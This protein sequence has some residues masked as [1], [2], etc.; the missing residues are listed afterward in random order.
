MK[1]VGKSVL[2]IILGLMMIAKTLPAQTSIPNGSFEDWINNGNSSDPQYWDT[3]NYELMQIPF[4][5]TTVVTKSTDHYGTGS[6]SVKLESKHIT[7]PSIDVPG[8]IT[9][10]KLNIDMISGTYSVT[11][12]VPIIDKPTHLKGYYKFIPKGGDSTLVGIGLFKT[13]AGITDTV[14]S[15]VFTTKT[16]APDWTPFYVWISYQS[17]VQPDTMNIIALSTAQASFPTPGTLLYLDELSL[18]YTTGV[19]GNEPPS[20]I[21]VYN[22]RE[23]RRLILYYDFPEPENTIV[24]LYNSIGQKIFSSSEGNITTGRSFIPYMNARGGLYILEVIHSGKKFFRKY[25]LNP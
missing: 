21:N 20:G 1:I 17:D 3:P 22:D 14:A 12:G 5:G 15:G 8:F 18:D 4:F 19:N 11:G 23:T 9:L 10:G 24:F 7:I 13:T 6:Y 25:I 2:L 16:A